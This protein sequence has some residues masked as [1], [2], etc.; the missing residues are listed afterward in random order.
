METY[1]IPDDEEANENRAL[2]GFVSHQC[3]GIYECH[4]KAPG[5]LQPQWSNQVAARRINDKKTSNKLY[6]ICELVYVLGFFQGK[7]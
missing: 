5:D 4:H 2:E 7:G 6:S 3:I 1:P